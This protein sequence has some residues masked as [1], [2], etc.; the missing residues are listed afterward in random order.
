MNKCKQAGRPMLSEQRRETL[1]SMYSLVGS[2]S[3]VKLCRWQKSMMRG[4]G[5][6]YKWTMYGIESHRCM[7]ATPSMACANKCVFCWR[8]NTNPT[9]TEWKWQVDNPH[10]IVEG[11]LT[12]HKTLVH[13]V[14]G[15]PGVTAESLEEAKNPKHC[16]LSLVGEPILYP[17]VNE[18]LHI[19]H[20]KGISTFLVNNGQF[21][22]A[23]ENLATVTQLYL[24]VDAPNKEVM[25]ILDRPVFADYWDRFNQSVL[26]MN[27]R[28]ERTVFRLTMIDGFNMSEDNLRE[29]KVLF[30]VGRPNFIELKRLTPAFSGNDRSILRMKNVPTWEGLK[31]YAA[32]LCETILDGKEYSVASVHEHSGCILLAQ[33]RFKVDGVWHTWIDFDKF[34]AMVLDPAVR[35]RIV[36]DGYLRPTPDWALPD[37]QSAGFDPAQCRRITPRR[38]KYMDANEGSAP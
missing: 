35:P 21:P 6:C 10:D 5:G 16:A 15:M 17:K 31:T 13:E 27:Q 28:R 22:E 1:G 4:M 33:N 38:Q 20:T 23:V 11:M 8:L 19:L 2:H 25:K 32:R 18:F 30:E 37:S 3:A 29:Y 34:N 12:S 9:A 36:A 14:Q 7:E 26:Y 24:S